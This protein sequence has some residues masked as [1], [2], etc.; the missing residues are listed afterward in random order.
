MNAKFRLFD[1]VPAGFIAE[2]ITHLAN[3]TCFL[4]SRTVA[5]ASVLALK[6]PVRLLGIT[7]SSRSTEDGAQT[8]QLDLGL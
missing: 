7:L 1:F 4:L 8:P 6:S 3:E 5:T 2:R